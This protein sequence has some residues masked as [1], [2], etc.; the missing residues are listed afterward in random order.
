MAHEINKMVYVGEL[1]WHGLGTE[2][3]ENAS[4]EQVRELGGFYTAEARPLFVPGRETPIAD[5]KAICRADSGEYLATVGAGYQIIQFDELAETG[6]KAAGGFGAIWHTAG[7]LGE[8]G[9][10]GWMLGELPNPIKV[11]NDESEI[12]KFVLLSSSHDGSGAA[13]LK[14]VATRVVCANT[15]GS[16]LRENGS[17]WRIIHTKNAATRLDEAARAFRE[18]TAGYE[19]FGELANA[20]A[21]V[22][23]SDA[24]RA[25]V[26]SAVV[27]FDE[28]DGSKHARLVEHREKIAE[29]SDFGTGVGSAMRGSAWAL[30]QG[31]TE[32]ADH[33]R[34]KAL[35]AASRLDSIWFGAAAELKRKG[36]ATLIEEAQLAA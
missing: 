23:L 13:V 12:R 10:R 29:L 6:V 25:R 18:V 22:R 32:W 5:R 14:N 7:T 31:V 30:F 19:R 36:L 4:W 17:E 15:L 16:A 3:P 28:N 8:Q 26:I 24:A 34:V 33:H 2:L 11:K 35:P 20:L 27:P 21:S 9:V 1:P